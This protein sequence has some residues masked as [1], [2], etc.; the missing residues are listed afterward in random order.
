MAINLF[1]SVRLLCLYSVQSRHC[2]LGL[3]CTR[4][5]NTKLSE[6]HGP[7]SACVSRFE[8]G[9]LPYRP[10][11]FGPRSDAGW[12]LI[13]CVSVCL[14][15]IGRRT[16]VFYCASF[17]SFLL[18]YIPFF[19]IKNIWWIRSIRQKSVLWWLD[20]HFATKTCSFCCRNC[21]ET[22]SSACDISV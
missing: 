8:S 17:L 18:F 4:W 12:P 1:L 21:V 5:K 11:A 10:S 19:L 15:S 6:H 16:C 22:K 2:D 20:S 9:P 14:C 3:W 13:V 7:A